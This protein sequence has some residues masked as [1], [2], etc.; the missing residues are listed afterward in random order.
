MTDQQTPPLTEE[1]A[2]AHAARRRDAEEWAARYMAAASRH[3]AELR[4]ETKRA[5]NNYAAAE[6]YRANLDRLAARV[7]ELESILR[8]EF[9]RQRDGEPCWCSEDHIHRMERLGKHDGRC[10]AVREL[11]KPAESSAPEA[12]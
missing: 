6:V 7:T 3:A 4:A 11:F 5:D 10:E 12:V 1:V 9:P 2:E 8:Y